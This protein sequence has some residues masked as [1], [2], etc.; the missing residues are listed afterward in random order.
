VWEIV[1]ANVGEIPATNVKLDLTYSVSE[2]EPSSHQLGAI[3]PHQQA[4]TTVDVPQTAFYVPALLKQTGEIT[5]EGGVRTRSTFSRESIP[6]TVHCKITYTQPPVLFGLSFR[7]FH[8]NQPIT[9]TKEGTV[10][11]SQSERADIR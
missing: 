7:E 4:T 6:M 5:P 11:S 3:F 2:F 9:I 1:V 8:T 10:F